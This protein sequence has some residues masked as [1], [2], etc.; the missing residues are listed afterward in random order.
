[1]SGNFESCPPRILINSLTVKSNVLFYCNYLLP[2]VQIFKINVYVKYISIYCREKRE[3][4]LPKSIEEMPQY[5]EKSDKVQFPIR[6]FPVSLGAYQY[7]TSVF[8]VAILRPKRSLLTF[9]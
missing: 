6:S 2:T 8:V 3:K 5:S 4:P 7:L 1:M 9:F